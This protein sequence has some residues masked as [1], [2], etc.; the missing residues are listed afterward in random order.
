MECGR[1]KGSFRKVW[2]DVWEQERNKAAPW[3]H[4]AT[5]E[6]QLECAM[7]RIPQ[8]LV[9]ALGLKG[10]YMCREIAHSQCTL[11]L[12]VT[13]LRSRLPMPDTEECDGVNKA[14]P[15][16]GKLRTRP[17][18]PNPTVWCPRQQVRLPN[19]MMPK[20]NTRHGCRTR[21]VDKC[22]PLSDE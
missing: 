22:A 15:W 19:R 5:R 20:G 11:Y 16:Y 9:K 18:K 4:S 6:E 8:S 21:T 2:E 14:K 3:R 13:Q 12:A 1:W 10:C 17:F 7:W